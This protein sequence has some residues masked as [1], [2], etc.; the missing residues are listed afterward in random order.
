[1]KHTAEMN[2]T[3]SFDGSSKVNSK[4]H[5]LLL[6]QWKKFQRKIKIL[7]IIKSLMQRST[8]SSKVDII[9]ATT[10][11]ARGNLMSERRQGAEKF[12]KCSHTPCFLI[13][14]EQH[15]PDFSSPIQ[16]LPLQI[17]SLNVSVISVC[18]F[19]LKSNWIVILKR[20]S[21]I[22]NDLSYQI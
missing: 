3:N 13:I 12:W 10:E 21:Y 20:P 16:I 11:C 5:L 15:S 7:I 18:L 9:Y 22:K 2:E 6:K 19:L 1:M 4:T 14:W 17:I 8:L